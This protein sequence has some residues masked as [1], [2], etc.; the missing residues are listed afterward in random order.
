MNNSRQHLVQSLHTNFILVVQHCSW[1]YF[2]MCPLWRWCLNKYTFMGSGLE[3][4]LMDVLPLDGH[5]GSRWRDILSPFFS[6]PENA[7]WGISFLLDITVPTSFVLQPHKWSKIFGLENHLCMYT[8]WPYSFYFITQPVNNTECHIVLWVGRMCPSIYF[9]VVDVAAFCL[10][11]FKHFYSIFMGW[12]S[13]SSGVQT[14]WN[15]VMSV[16]IPS[17]ILNSRS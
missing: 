13:C 7:C 14:S 6:F 11:K 4:D 16:S 12:V 9:Q 17:R 5:K 1:F 3:K 10:T 2:M 8:Q 15:F